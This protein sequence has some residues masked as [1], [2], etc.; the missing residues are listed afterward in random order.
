LEDRRDIIYLIEA[1]V[2]GDIAIGLININ[3]YYYKIW[4]KKS[5]S[6]INFTKR[7]IDEKFVNKEIYLKEIN[8]M[9]ENL[10]VQFNKNSDL[11]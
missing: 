9:I 1:Y 6:E 4:E 3:S 7:F 2:L 11:K 5:Y 8:L 10:Y